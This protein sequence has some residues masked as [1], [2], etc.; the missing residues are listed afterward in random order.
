MVLGG[1]GSRGVRTKHK[2]G[3][4]SGRAGRDD[5]AAFDMSQTRSSVWRPRATAAFARALFA[6]GALELAIGAVE[7]AIGAVELAIGAVGPDSSVEGRVGDMRRAK[8]GS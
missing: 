3:V 6:I 4:K 5:L 2:W 1:I 7:L 8:R